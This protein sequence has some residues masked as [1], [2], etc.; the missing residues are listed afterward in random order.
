MLTEFFL[1]EKR[2]TK[3]T[4]KMDRLKCRLPSLA[5]I[6]KKI[7]LLI[8]DSTYKST[9]IHQVSYTAVDQSE[10]FIAINS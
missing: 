1:G 7:A 10:S 3:I 6:S 9:P 4:R 5:K 8:N 2:Q